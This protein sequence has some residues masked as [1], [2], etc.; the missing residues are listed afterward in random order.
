MKTNCPLIMSKI[1]VLVWNE[2]IHEQKDK[3][4]QAVYGKEGIHGAIAKFLKKFPEFD[5]KTATLYDDE[6][7]LSEEALKETDVLIWWGHAGHHMVMDEFVDRM[8]QRI[9]DG[10]DRKSVG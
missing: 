1:R 7:G 2:Y 8:Q 10:I 5:V 4:V 9:L 6:M 3:A